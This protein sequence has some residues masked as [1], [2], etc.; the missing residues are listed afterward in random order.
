MRHVIA[1][2]ATLALI[3]AVIPAT[4][5][6]APQGGTWIVQL[7]AGVNPAAAAPGLAKQHGGS[8]E[9]IYRHALN[10]FAFR[11]SAAAAAALERNP[12]VTLVEADPLTPRPS[13]GSAPTES[14]SSSNHLLPCEQPILETPPLAAEVYPPGIESSG[15]PGKRGAYLLSG[16]FSPSLLVRE[17]SGRDARGLVE[18]DETDRRFVSG[19]RRRVVAPPFEQFTQKQ[20]TEVP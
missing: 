9:H 10:G 20:Q 8:V 6:A 1:M 5:S 3:L 16:L 14:A 11:G 7:K 19:E 12:K 2:L 18:G 13:R 15:R 4:V 17:L